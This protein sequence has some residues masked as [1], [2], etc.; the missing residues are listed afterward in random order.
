MQNKIWI[1]TVTILIL[2]AAGV[3]IAYNKYLF[4]Q[5]SPAGKTV[6]IDGYNVEY[7]SDGQ[8]A[9][10]TDPK[11]GIKLMTGKDLKIPA[12]F[13]T[14]FPIYQNGKVTLISPDP[15]FPMLSIESADAIPQAMGW[16]KEALPKQGWTISGEEQATPELGQIYFGNDQY[17]GAVTFAKDKQS[18]LTMITLSAMTAEEAQK[19]GQA[20]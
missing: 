7:S 6:Q 12:T 14:E 2:L 5:N 16:F 10:I 17:S 8:T 20:Q 1:F 4:N 13:P 15:S 11:T 3:Y 19:I 18:G 9:T